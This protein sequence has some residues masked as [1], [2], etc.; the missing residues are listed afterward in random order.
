MPFN[1]K[2]WSPFSVLG[3]MVTGKWF[4]TISLSI[5]FFIVGFVTSTTRSLA[6]LKTSLNK[7]TKD[8]VCGG[9]LFFFAR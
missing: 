2:T 5:L 1:L 9:G 8:I 6:V 4:V 7:I 3:R